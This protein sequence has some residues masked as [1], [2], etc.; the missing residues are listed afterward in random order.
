M[1]RTYQNSLAI[2]NSLPSG[3]QP[4]YFELVH[5]AVSASYNLN[6][7]YITVGKN[8]LYA[9]QWRVSSND[10]ADQARSH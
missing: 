4:A 3:T 9:S 5:H 6:N 8:N 10:L 7:M 2:Y 1:S